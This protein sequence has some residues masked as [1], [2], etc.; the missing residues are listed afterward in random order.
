[1]KISLISCVLAIFLLGNTLLLGQAD[2]PRNFYPK[3]YA[4]RDA[5]IQ[6]EELKHGT[7]VI[8]LATNTRKLASIKKAI[9]L[10][11]NEKERNR[12][13]AMLEK[14]ALDTRNQNLWLKAAF[15]SIYTFTPVLFMPDTV[16]IQLKT[17]VRQGIFLGP[18]LDKIDPSLTLD[19]KFFVAFYGANTSD[20]KTNN[21]GI[22]VLDSTLQS[23]RSPFPYFT[24]RTSIRRMFEEFF[25]K[26]EGQNHFEKLVA[27]FQKRLEEF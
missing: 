9:K 5:I 4:E 25:N 1:M 20:E 2:Q 19:G 27:K 16:A 17:G 13:G 23:L 11:N 3:Q 7:L 14:T 15:D 12:L 24:G 6:M 8:R 26:S 18:S 10:A 22:T 21:Q